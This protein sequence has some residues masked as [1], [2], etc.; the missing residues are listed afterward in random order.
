MADEKNK[1]KSLATASTD[2]F[3]RVQ[4]SVP[5]IRHIQR[6]P[7]GFI[8]KN[9]ASFGIELCSALGCIGSRTFLGAARSERESVGENGREAVSGLG[10]EPRP[11]AFSAG[12]V[13]GCGGSRWRWVLARCGAR[14]IVCRVEG[15]VYGSADAR[16]SER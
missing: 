8:G 10:P 16:V 15:L 13:R 12:L 9:S 1:L 2:V 5:E 4:D 7:V 3:E 11:Q 14:S 6:R